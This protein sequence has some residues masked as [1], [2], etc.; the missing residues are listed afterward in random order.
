MADNTEPLVSLVEV[1]R[2]LQVDVNTYNRK[3][4]QRFRWIGAA[5]VLVLLVAIG[6]FFGYRQLAKLNATV[7]DCIQ[8][9]GDCYKSG[10]RRSGGAA[11]FITDQGKQ[12]V[13]AANWCSAKNPQS[14]AEFSKCVDDALKELARLKSKTSP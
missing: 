1:M 7:A 5:L 10:A 6:A 14:L 3:Q 9:T 13:I 11:V 2:S 4:A 12:N 8:T